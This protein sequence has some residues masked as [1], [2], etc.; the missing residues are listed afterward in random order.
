M[1]SR[2]SYDLVEEDPLI[3][4]FFRDEG[5]GTAGPFPVYISLIFFCPLDGPVGWKNDPI[6]TALQGK[7]VY[8]GISA[9][10]CTSKEQGNV[11]HTDPGGS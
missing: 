4:V 8:I 11:G 6:D 7:N 5:Y 3:I 1:V 9:V 10:T 2:N